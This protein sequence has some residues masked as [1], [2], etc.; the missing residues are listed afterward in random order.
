MADR[1]TIKDQRTGAEYELPVTYGTYPEYGASTP[2][3]ELRKIKSS[4]EDF[5]LLSYDPAYMNTASCKS[6]VTFIDGDRGILRYRGYPIEQLAEESSYLE[7]AYLTLFGELPTE[8]ELAEWTHHI[9]HHTFVHENVK[10]LMDGFHHDAHPMGMFV[11]TVAALSTF[12]PDA[13]K[14]QDHDIRLKQIQRLIAKVP[15]IAAFAYRHSIG[16]PYIYPDND[17]SFTGNFL[18]MMFRISEPVYDPN[19]V[20]ERALDLLFILHVDHE[21]NC[22]AS[23]MRGIG[24]SHADPYVSVAAAAAA[25]YGPLH[26]GA[27]EQVMNMLLKIDRPPFERNRSTQPCAGQ[28]E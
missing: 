25:L 5:G 13:R 4:D 14:V 11:S 1:L 7:V 28:V 19:P 15:T 12:Y 9:L 27:N 22:S 8:R 23:V 18:S 20:L 21:Q 3:I 17:L 24:S 10:K 26:G 2:A 6:A 16:L